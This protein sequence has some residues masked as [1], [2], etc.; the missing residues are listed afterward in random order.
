MELK[1]QLEGLRARIGLSNR[2]IDQ[3][4]RY[5]DWQALD[6]ERLNRHADAMEAVHLAFVERLYAHL[7]LF[8]PLASIL[9]NPATL[10]RLKASQLDYYKRLW[11]G[12][13]DPDYVL[14]R[15]RVGLVHQHVGVDLKW[16]LGAYR[17]YLA[18]MVESLLGDSDATRT[19]GSLL[20]VVFFDISLAVDT[21]SA[22]QRQ[23]LEDSEA[24][25]ARALRGAHDGIWDWDLAHDRLYVSERWASMLGLPRD[26]L[27]ETSAAW[28]ARV[29][30]DDLPALRQAI[31][32]HLR[33]DAPWLSHEYR[34][35]QQN[36]GYLWVQVRGVAEG[37][38]MA[39]SQSDISQRKATEHQLSHAARHD[40]LTG[41]ANR[42]RLDE[43][44]QQAL[45]RQLKP[46]ARQAALLF[47]DLDR[48][49]LINDSLGH[50]V[51]DRVL[52]EVAQRLKRCLRPG[53]HLARFGGDEFV[54]LLDD[55]AHLGD[56]EQV[57]KR[58]LESLHQPLH[59]DDRTLVVSASIGFTALQAEGQTI[60]ALQAADLA[61][62][63]A[64]ESGKAQIARFSQDLQT[65][66]KQR[67]E[68]ESALA[69]ALARQEFFLHYQPICRVD[70]G[71][72]RLVA[73]EALLRW[74]QGDALVSPARFI[75]A[76]E[77]SGEIIAVGD[78][79]LREACRQTRAWQRA[80]Q[81]DLRCSVNLSSRQLHQPGFAQRLRA[82]LAE[83]GLDPASLVLE[84]TESLLMQD[85]ADTLACLRELACQGVRLALDDF[86]TGYSSLGYLKRFPL[87]I[88]KV[89]RSFIAGV[90][91]DA[92]LRTISRAII[93]LGASLG[94][95]VIAEGVESPAQLDFLLDEDCRYAQGFWFSQP[96]APDHLQRL[97]D[98][99]DSL[100]C[101][102][103]QP[104]RTFEGAQR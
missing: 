56:A 49:K 45:Q 5:L 102:L 31:D 15:L 89:D 69:Q 75:P 18:Q 53:D 80:G 90:P 92:E 4:C 54:V 22:A 14:N 64:K 27:G 20:K 83:T 76:L 29:H 9:R 101:L 58:M 25:F 94:L 67:L 26:A 103:G 24:R 52:V 57:A 86:G 72:P 43:L 65:A 100:A 78:W 16:Y 74:R 35:R 1:G 19:L 38:R 95:E 70:Q 12:P 99:E 8:P 23:A 81:A 30:P 60:D 47:I 73:V 36:G 79:V 37:Q 96:R 28:F 10:A 2:E 50:A 66:A 88:L 7:D 62:Y 63:R 44:L 33:G 87:H 42:L 93:G 82:I 39:G 17:L 98:G 6:A 41:L 61:L 71:Q 48:F 34:I 104:S 11:S 77:E 85:G 51:G 3:R 68:L 32:A 55:L 97:L 84:I 91:D 59:L 13:Y 21:Y 40:P 46:G